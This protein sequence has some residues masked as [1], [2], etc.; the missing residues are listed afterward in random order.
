MFCELDLDGDGYLT[1][2]DP[3][4]AEAV[5]LWGEKIPNWLLRPS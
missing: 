4:Y 1:K 5:S 2:E 3:K